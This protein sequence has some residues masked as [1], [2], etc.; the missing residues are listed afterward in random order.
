MQLTDEQIDR[1]ARQIIVPGIGAV[2]Q[3]RLCATRVRVHGDPT[4]C[5]YV[6]AYARAVG[7]QISAGEA[8]YQVLAGTAATTH[9]PASEH[10]Q[11]AATAWYRLTARGWT[12]GLGRSCEP[13]GR[14]PV[15]GPPTSEISVAANEA[16][17]AAAAADTINTLVARVLGWKSG[18]EVHEV[19]LD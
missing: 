12:S 14:L 11:P 18:D 10:R 8:D 9:S 17:H 19:C 7:M 13:T 6:E 1:F 4:G 3:E 15:E 2:G 5:R 16:L